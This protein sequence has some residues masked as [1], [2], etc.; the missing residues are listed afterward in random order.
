ML[1]NGRRRPE[2]RLKDSERLL[3]KRLGIHVLRLLH[4]KVRQ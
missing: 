3:Q 2:R 1:W 4:P